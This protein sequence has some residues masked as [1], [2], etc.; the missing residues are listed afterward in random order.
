MTIQLIS[1]STGGVAGNGDSGFVNPLIGL[2]NPALDWQLAT[3]ANPFSSD[4]TKVLFHSKATNLAGGTDA[5]GKHDL[6]LADLAT[7]V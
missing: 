7:P 1:R 2:P 4:G 6:F 3:D 5:N